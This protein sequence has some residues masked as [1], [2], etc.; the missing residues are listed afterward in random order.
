MLGITVSETVKY[1]FPPTKRDKHGDTD[2]VCRWC[3]RWCTEKSSC[4]NR[5]FY[6]QGDYTGMRPEVFAS[7]HTPTEDADSVPICDDCCKKF[8]LDE[9]QCEGKYH[10]D[11]I[12]ILGCP[13]KVDCLSRVND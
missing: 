2:D 9:Y 3:F 7:E 6:V 10:K 12:V 1:A 8:N 11:H 13:F 5:Y 4:S